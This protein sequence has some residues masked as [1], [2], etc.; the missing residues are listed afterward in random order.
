M[1]A[2]KPAPAGFWQDRTGWVR[3]KQVLFLEPLPGGARWS[4]AFGSLLLFVLVLQILTGVLLV[5]SYAPSVDTAWPSVKYIQDEQPL[6]GFVRALHHWGS[7]AMVV[8]L[9]F[10]L[11]QVF[12]WGAYKKP[13]EL[14]WMVGVLLLFLTLGMA[15]TGYLLPW[16]E[17]A[18]WATKVGLGIAG[19]APVVGDPLRTLLQGGP[20]M[21]NLTLTRFFALHAF[22]LPGALIGLVVVHLYLF[23]AHGVTPPWWESAARLRVKEEPFWPRQVLMDA[24]LALAF[25]VGLGLW[26][27][28]RPAPL[29]A[30]ADPSRPYEARPEWYFMF[31]FQSLRYFK[32]PYEIVG[33][34]V[35]PLAFFLVLFFWPLLDRSPSRD[36]RRRPV[37]MGLLAA[38]VAGLVGLTTFAIATDVRMKE[39]ELAKAKE[40][41]PAEPAGPIQRADVVRLYNQN[42][43]VTCHGVD[44]KG[45]TL[46]ATVPSMPDF[47]SMAWQVGRTDVDLIHQIQEGKQPLMPGYRE[48][49]GE[50]QILALAV[51]VRAFAV[52]PVELPSPSPAAAG[53]QPGPPPGPAPAAPPPVAHLAPAETFRVYCAACH[54]PE[55]RGSI[56]RKAGM[57]KIPDFTDPKWQDAAKSAELKQS[58]LE[59]KPP[60]MPPM[61]KLLGPADAEA[62]V[63]FVRQFRGAKAPVAEAPKP[64]PVPP[65]LP[66]VV[67][68]PDA[69]AAGPTPAAPS[70][71]AAERLHVASGLFGQ[72]CLVC[73]GTD[74]RGTAM[75]P[76][77]PAIPDFTNRAWQANASS[78]QLPA[79]ILNGKGTLMP[80]FAGRVSPDQAEALVAYVRA[81]GPEPVRADEGPASDFEKRFREMEAEWDELQRQLRALQK[82]AK[83]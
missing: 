37:A 25:L 16:D 46:R 57:A 12:V 19:T 65:S 68:A 67:P 51:Y 4:A 82:P 13:R 1:H 40:P 64:P 47:T 11:V 38:G 79:S 43:C 21:G 60:F 18:Y 81:F 34:F 72:Y 3:L 78:A 5:T 53:P 22:L 17:R 42:N 56:G 10:H 36:P 39:P 59:G 35:L 58:V 50:K 9:L 15:F 8:L 49:L 73:H 20:L 80:S 45:S 71:A 2:E 63:A 7:S 55:G 52:G 66:Q 77:M 70:A 41:A 24:V 28:W 29:E 69:A 75:R 76:S 27:A 48:K 61:M 6:G 83:P 44:G 74:G 31:L 54:D 33:T 30:Q 23:R 32:G 14:T 62:M 26:C